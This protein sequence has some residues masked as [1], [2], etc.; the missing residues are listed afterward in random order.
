MEEMD[1]EL[2]TQKEFFFFSKE[3]IKHKNKQLK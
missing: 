3:K 1:D 2:I